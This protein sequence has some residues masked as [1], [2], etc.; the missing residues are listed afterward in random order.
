MIVSEREE[1]IPPPFP[2][3]SVLGNTCWGMALTIH[4]ALMDETQL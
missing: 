4:G 2:L 3:E 1:G